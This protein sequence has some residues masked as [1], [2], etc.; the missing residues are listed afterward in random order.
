MTRTTDITNFTEYRS[1]HRV[2]HTQV[3]QTGRPLFITNN[4]KPDVVLLSAETFDGIQDLIELRE[5]LISIEKSEQEFA[6][7][8]GVEARRAIKDIA[9]KHGLDLDR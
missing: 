4:G 7:G 5:S 3:H 2:F 1:N 9:S 6:A 8:K